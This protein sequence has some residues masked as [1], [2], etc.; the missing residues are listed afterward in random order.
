[1]LAPGLALLTLSIF[2]KLNSDDFSTTYFFCNSSRSHVSIARCSSYSSNANLA[3]RRAT[4]KIIYTKII[5]I[6]FPRGQIGLKGQ[7]LA[8]AYTLPWGAK[9]QHA[10]LE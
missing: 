1:M 10:F 4:E 7:V 5:R 8:P 2:R 3:P 6:E 9:T